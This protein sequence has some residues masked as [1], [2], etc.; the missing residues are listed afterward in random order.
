MALTESLPRAGL[1]LWQSVLETDVCWLFHQMESRGEALGTCLPWG[2]D[3]KVPGEPG[4]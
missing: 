4:H 2:R 3:S 1:C